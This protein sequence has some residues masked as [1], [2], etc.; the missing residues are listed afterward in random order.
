MKLLQRMKS[1]KGFTLV[2]MVLVIAILAVI[3]A[4][5]V[6]GVDSYVKRIKLME[7]DD[8]AR[9][10]FMAAQNKLMTLRSSGKSLNFEGANLVELENVP[11]FF[12]EGEYS[13]NE[14]TRPKFTY[15]KSDDL[16][17]I[18][19][20]DSNIISL[21]AIEDQ[22]YSNEFVIEYDAATGTVFGVFYTEDD[23][24]LEDYDPEN[25]ERGFEERLKAGGTIGYYGGGTL[26]EVPVGEE[27]T[28]PIIKN[29]A[30]EKLVVYVEWPDGFDEAEKLYFTL[31]I[32]GPEKGAASNMQTVE[33]ISKDDSCYITKDNY[34]TII[35]D[36]LAPGLGSDNG[37]WDIPS[38]AGDHN[39]SYPFVLERDFKGWVL[40]KNLVF[41]SE[42]GVYYPKYKGK[43]WQGAE[44]EG[45]EWLRDDYPMDPQDNGSSS[46]GQG[47]PGSN[48]NSNYIINP[49]SDITVYVT[50]YD[51]SGVYKDIPTVKPY[52][53]NSYFNA[54]DGTTAH[55]SAGRHLQNLANYVYGP[56]VSDVSL[57]A[58]INFSL[59]RGEDPTQ[60][61]DVYDYWNA[62][63]TYASCY[64]FKPIGSQFVEASTFVPK[65]HGNNHTISY[66]KIDSRMHKFTDDKTAGYSN[67][68]FF[69]E[70]YNA[71]GVENLTF[72]RPYVY[73]ETENTAVFVGHCYGGS[74][75]ENI[76]IINPTV[77]GTKNVGA[78]CGDFSDNTQVMDVEVY[79]AEYENNYDFYYDEINGKYANNST[80][81]GL[82][83]Y[84]ES[85]NWDDP[86][87]DPYS[88]FYIEGTTEEA[89]V[90]GIMGRSNA[91]LK[92]SY[93]S[94]RVISKGV[95]GGMVGYNTGSIQN[96]YVGG[97]TFEGSYIGKTELGKDY[98]LINVD[99]KNG[100]GGIVGEMAD[101][102]FTGCYST[103]SVAYS[104]GYGDGFIGIDRKDTDV[105]NGAYAFGWVIKPDG[106]VDRKYSN[107]KGVMS[108]SDSA[109]AS[110][111]IIDAQPYDK[112]LD[113]E[114]P[115]KT[116]ATDKTVH[117]G[118]WP[119]DP[120]LFG[121]FYWE[122]V[123]EEYFIK[124]VGYNAKEGEKV[125]FGELKDGVTVENFGY[126]YYFTN[127]A[128]KTDPNVMS[129]VGQSYGSVPAKIIESIENAT[130]TQP[131]VVMRQWAQDGVHDLKEI[132][133]DYSY[134][135]NV[136]SKAFF[137]NPDFCGVSMTDNLGKRSEN[138]PYHI[139]NVQQLKNINNSL[140]SNFVQ[141]LDIDASGET[142]KPLG[143]FTD[144]FSGK[145]NG[146][147]K[148]LTIGKLDTKKS[149]SEYGNGYGL[150]GVTRDATI[151]RVK[152]D[153]P[154]GTFAI[155]NF[156]ARN[157]LGGIVGVAVGGT[158]NECTVK[159]FNVS[160]TRCPKIAIGGIVG[161]SSANITNCYVNGNGTGDDGVSKSSV[162]ISNGGTNMN[163]VSAAGGI[164]GSASGAISGCK[165]YSF[166]MG[167]D[168]LLTDE[169]KNDGT[170]NGTLIIAGGI[171]GN[172]VDY[173]GRTTLSVLNC[174]SEASL[175]R[176]SG[177]NSKGKTT[178]E[179]NVLIHPI[180][181][182]K[183]V[184]DTGRVELYKETE[185]YEETQKND[186]WLW[187]LIWEDVIKPFLQRI[188]LLPM[189]PAAP[190]NEPPVYT[191][192]T[193]TGII[194]NSD[195]DG[196]NLGTIDVTI[197]NC[198]ATQ[199]ENYYN[200]R[201]CGK[202]DITFKTE[203]ASPTNDPSDVYVA[204]PPTM[205]N[206]IT[207]YN[208]QVPTVGIYA[209]Y[210]KTDGVNNSALAAKIIDNSVYSGSTTN[211]Q[212][213]VINEDTNVE[214]KLDPLHKYGIFVDFGRFEEIS[215][216]V[217]GVPQTIS[218]TSLKD[219]DG[220]TLHR[221]ENGQYIDID[222][223]SAL[224]LN[225]GENTITI[226]YKEN[227][228][229]NSEICTYTI[230]VPAEREPYAG[231]YEL[232]QQGDTTHLDAIYNDG[233]NK[234][235]TV[236]H[237]DGDIK[238]GKCGVMIEHFTSVNPRNVAFTA[239][240]SYTENG[241]QKTISNADYVLVDPSH[242]GNDGEKARANGKYFDFYEISDEVYSAIPEDTDYTIKVIYSGKAIAEGTF[243]KDVKVPYLGIYGAMRVRNKYNMNDESLI[244]DVATA[245]ISNSY[246]ISKT[247]N[248][249]W[250]GNYSENYDKYYG[251]HIMVERG[252]DISKIELTL[253]KLDKSTQTVEVK[254]EYKV[255]NAA[256][257]LVGAPNSATVSFFEGLMFDSYKLPDD[258]IQDVA[259]ISAT[260]I[261]SD[262]K[263]TQTVNAK[264]LDDLKGEIIGHEHKFGA[265]ESVD[266]NT[267]KRT[268]EVCGFVETSPHNWDE[269]ETIPEQENMLRFTCE[270]CKATKEE[271]KRP[272]EDIK[273]VGI[274]VRATD[275]WNNK[276][277]KTWF[278]NDGGTIDVSDNNNCI[279]IGE[280]GILINK[281]FINDITVYVDETP[282]VS[283]TLTVDDMDNGILAHFND[284]NQLRLTAYRIPS[285][286]LKN[287]VVTITVKANDGKTL[288]SQDKIRVR[289]HT[290]V[291]EWQPPTGDQDT[292]YH[293]GKCTAEFCPLPEGELANELH[294]V[295]ED[296]VQDKPGVIKYTCNICGYSWEEVSPPDVALVIV[297]PNDSS[298]YYIKY[299][300]GGTTKVTGNQ[301]IAYTDVYLAIDISRIGDADKL[302]LKN[303]YNSYEIIQSHSANLEGFVMPSEL[304]KFTIIKK[305]D[306]GGVRLLE[307]S[308]SCIL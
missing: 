167:D 297:N 256:Y 278:T 105:G 35:L 242:I 60:P 308:Y 9:S 276:I 217:N 108:I 53:V 287:E 1:K 97:H 289:E 293:Y 14:K 106:K 201:V 237:K 212:T 80:E 175:T 191:F 85:L 122:K 153:Y 57:D 144:Y 181:P 104:D 236:K 292:K 22:L 244:D 210:E 99:G 18:P 11:D 224:N 24:A 37:Q 127:A 198:T 52:P 154:S 126:G 90:G 304:S 174:E 275:Q 207:S 215:V 249:M 152:V 102:G 197:T 252:A 111:S 271:Q 182:T 74:N 171:V 221:T 86:T 166:D 68:A 118:D 266:N 93:C 4:F 123:G 27:I 157:G 298:Q 151:E 2:E 38:D 233:K 79:V 47:Y 209:L 226:V 288:I 147:N 28:T 279:L 61:Y 306:G 116:A 50:F 158:I 34:S 19:E 137:F 83:H 136:G 195:S 272:P 87:N 248:N 199:G 156:S 134:N 203:G 98:C 280:A 176:P 218:L 63:E 82:K 223:S 132:I 243:H 45:T 7:L 294:H 254:P 179:S 67:T 77:I 96:V 92:K 208:K 26:V 71:G 257:I 89:Y 161:F 187:K 120:P 230:N 139:R 214:S 65:F 42:R 10:I 238:L 274:Y 200:S 286:M 192:N 131:T 43:M 263:T 12:K 84:Q 138:E 15:I 114:Y 66:L 3:L 228:T 229:T 109:L 20:G 31:S 267:H 284:K 91:N 180:A 245:V 30:M 17:K 170:F 186:D 5:A 6:P 222:V 95:A 220:K 143:S 262:G 32:V 234:N 250:S 164:A 128:Y 129:D 56:T 8:S 149:D 270:D 49:G 146:N 16:K 232:Y 283:N 183:F 46:E 48:T 25:M 184:V 58:D 259:E 299:T 260:Y 295:V 211:N 29:G 216:K 165:V 130:N 291:A 185:E 121:I 296:A 94:V 150:F 64:E 112:T 178:F 261:C 135:S 76:K 196:N 189:D 193:G 88:K 41:D 141:D 110:A 70:L 194:P 188:G 21:G 273:Y 107:I 202:G 51:K 204:V 124:S 265:Y 227:E 36:S 268:C 145:Y 100:S 101:G 169:I 115:Y 75:F 255:E 239:E 73:G 59:S 246:K 247:Y 253:T 206:Y 142:W 303:C 155:E 173:L 81:E 159:N 219:M 162:A 54:L 44:M 103:A 205:T 163:A 113:N 33:I 72:Y 302:A 13:D 172:N 125:D 277:Y 62:G 177:I 213:I 225:N 258:V 290:H 40:K 264:I 140:G 168:K 240:I 300:D 78:I 281:T 23:G 117:V 55:I 133:F 241:E 269:G 251:T 285:S 305:I 39:L 119:V 282:I 160:A 307:Y 190:N 148:N 231:V 301:D 235:Q 69:A